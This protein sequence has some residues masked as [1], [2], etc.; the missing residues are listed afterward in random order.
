MKKV[1]LVVLLIFAG[2]MFR[3]NAQDVITKLDGSEI[4]SKVVEIDPAYVK[5]KLY[6]NQDGPTYVVPKTE[7]FRITYAGGRVELFNTATTATPPVT[8]GTPVT[9][10]QPPQSPVQTVPPQ[11]PQV[12]VTAYPYGSWKDQMKVKAP[13]LYQQYQKKN[14]LKNTGWWT[15]GGGSLLAVV[16]FAVADKDEVSR[17]S[18]SITY[19]LSGPGAVVYV[20]GSITA[21]AGIITAIVGYAQRGRVKRE[22][23][24]RSSQYSE[25]PHF[26]FRPNGLA[27]VF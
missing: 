1:F 20:V 22:Y 26:E 16:G 14:R 21:T 9:G 11:Q 4:R 24:S 27:F 7:L 2:T 23:L 25:K 10:Y 6:D 18:T 19:Q 8:A 15:F 3:A 12:P 17:T 5:Y 13:D